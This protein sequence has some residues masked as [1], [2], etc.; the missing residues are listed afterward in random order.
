MD[1]KLS[2]IASF[3]ESLPVDESM[4]DC[5]FTVLPTEMAT[6]GGKTTNTGD[7]C[8]NKNETCLGSENKKTCKNYST[9]CNDSK[10]GSC[11]NGENPDCVLIVKPDPYVKPVH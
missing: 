2:R 7:S 11:T 5:Q 10:N 4:E 9:Y 6:L 3:I 1:K 8:T